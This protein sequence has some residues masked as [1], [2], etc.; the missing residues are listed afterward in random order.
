MELI[1]GNSSIFVGSILSGSFPVGFG[2]VGSGLR[3]GLNGVM[4]LSGVEVPGRVSG[5]LFPVNNDNLFSI[6]FNLLLILFFLRSLESVQAFPI[7]FCFYYYLMSQ[8]YRT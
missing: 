4:I 6:L 8:N 1:F 3:S 5:E 2:V 7:S